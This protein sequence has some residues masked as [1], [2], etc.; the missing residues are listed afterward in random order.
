MGDV[1][2]YD[3]GHL[4]YE[5]SL[6]YDLYN[7]FFNYVWLLAADQLSL[8]ELSMDCCYLI[9]RGMNVISLFTLCVSL[10]FCTIG[11]G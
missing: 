7:M 1:D 8:G 11:L 4:G 3:I 9:N 5:V 2:T 6:F 10:C